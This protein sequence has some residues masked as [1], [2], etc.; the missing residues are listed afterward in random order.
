[1]KSVVLL[2]SGLDSSVCFAE[3]VHAGRAVLALTFDY[4]QRAAE[5]ELLMAKAQAD[6]AGV[7][8]R[9]VKLDF[10][11]QFSANALTS[12]SIDVPTSQVDIDSMEASVE[13]AKSVWVPNRNGIFLSIAAGFAESCGAGLV[14]TGFNVE[15][16]ATFPDNT[17]D[18]ME[19]FTSSLSFST[20]NKVRISSP[21]VD[22][23]KTQIYKRGIELGVD[24]SVVWPCYFSG[25]QACGQ[26]E[27]C[28][29][30]ERAKKKATV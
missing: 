4:G 27:S 25:D 19:Q 29:R 8:H 5:R 11:S 9:V 30:F 17:K 10:F 26:C 21:T 20:S 24:F 1:M 16:A 12:T 3:E 7:P 18:Y 22:M 23:D 2:S 14:V 28:Q 13:S 15:E 6:K